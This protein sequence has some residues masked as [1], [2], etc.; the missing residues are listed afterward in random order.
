MQQGHGNAMPSRSELHAAGQRGLVRAI[1]HAGGFL[2]VAQV[3][4]HVLCKGVSIAGTVWMYSFFHS[5]HAFQSV[6]QV[7]CSRHSV[8]ACPVLGFPPPCN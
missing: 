7:R 5:L 2:A 8:A 1:E 4:V 3:R 6:D